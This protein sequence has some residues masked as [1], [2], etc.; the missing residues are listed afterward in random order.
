MSAVRHLCALFF[1][2]FLCSF[3]LEQANAE[4]PQSIKPIA[5]KPVQ[6]KME[7]AWEPVP[8]ARRYLLQV[9][10]TQSF[11]DKLI[12]LRVTDARAAIELVPA[13]AYF[14]RVAGIDADGDLGNFSSVQKM[15]ATRAL[16]SQA[17]PVVA[18]APKPAGE[19]T[20]PKPEPSASATVAS[21]AV[22][23]PPSPILFTRLSAGYGGGWA[24]QRSSSGPALIEAS[25]VAFNSFRFAGQIEKGNWAADLLLGFQPWHYQSNNAE[26]VDF[27][28]ALTANRWDVGVFVHEKQSPWYGGLRFRLEGELQ[29]TGPE[30]VSIAPLGYW[31]I[32][33]GRVWSVS[34]LEAG[35][36]TGLFFRTQ[37]EVA[38][39]GPRRGLG[40][41]IKAAYA[42]EGVFNSWTPV[43]ELSAYPYYRLQSLSGRPE[44]TVETNAWFSMVW[45]FSD[46]VPAAT[47]ATAP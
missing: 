24:L 13:K 25:G 21:V 41:E 9:S 5:V 35:N 34:N 47:V 39:L 10:S 17:P 33:V 12:E 20:P 30:T 8:G 42:F 32:T 6:L 36:A 26:I 22:P 45:N 1:A 4:A 31:A 19:V 18:E 16:A 15:D 43:I 29:R 2:L 28:P 40:A 27:Q 14:W 37:L 7:F 11:K 38:P 46:P 3:V 44:W 23:Q